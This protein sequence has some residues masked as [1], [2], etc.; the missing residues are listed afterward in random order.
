MMHRAPYYIVY[1]GGTFT[2][3][4]LSIVWAEAVDAEEDYEHRF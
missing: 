4:Y 3:L 1:P 2:L